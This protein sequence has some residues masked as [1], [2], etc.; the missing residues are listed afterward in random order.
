[1]TGELRLP[2]HYVIIDIDNNRQKILKNSC[3][4]PKV[5]EYILYLYSPLMNL[6]N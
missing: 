6:Q 1:M 2:F 4:L 3:K 5:C